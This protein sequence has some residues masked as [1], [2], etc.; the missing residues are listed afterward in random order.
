[1][2]NESGLRFRPGI[3]RLE[4]RDVPALLAPIASPGGGVRAAVGDFNHDGRADVAAVGAR[5][6]STGIYADLVTNPGSVTVSLSKGDGT[7]QRS[8]SLSGAK[9]YYLEYITV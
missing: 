7:L 1:M 3:E 5:L 2:K 9:G 4:A 8:A 6:E